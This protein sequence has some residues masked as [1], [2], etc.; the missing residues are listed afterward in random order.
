MDWNLVTS[1]NNADAAY[2]VFLKQ[3]IKLYDDCFPLKTIDI[4]KKSILSPW[5]TKGIMKSSKRK[6]KLY[7]KFLKQKTYKN[8]KRYKN[9]KNIFE[10]VKQR[11]K[12]NYFANL[13]TKHQN[14]AKKLWQTIKEAIGK[15]KIKTNNF[16]RKMKIENEEIYDPAII[17][18]SFN[19][20]FTNIGSNLAAKIPHSEKHFT[21]YLN[22]SEV[23]MTEKELTSEEFE[24][25]FKPLKTN[26]ANGYDDINSN[27]VKDVYKELTEPLFHICKLSIRSGVF[28][29]KMKIAK[30]TPLF[31]SDEA[32]LLKNYRPI[33][34]LPTFSKILERII[35]NRIYS[36]IIEN[37]MLYNK[38]FGFRENCS[39]DLAILKLA[40]EIHESFEK[41][42]YTLGVFVDLSKA[43]DTVD[44]EILLKKLSFFG[45]NGLNLQWFRSYLSNRKQ[46]ISYN[47]NEK[48]RMQP[49]FVEFRRVQYSVHCCF[50]YM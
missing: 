8:E 31:K 47:N 44:H 41:H 17:A 30:V 16:P 23:V 4:K 42:E 22:Q 40:Q 2:E 45:I 48:S 33:S 18:D 32:D 12:K 29:N 28:P 49:I 7:L 1:T 9:Y 34:V 46:F 50:F 36:H 15:T 35:Y 24:S 38:Q 37:N 43:F 26:K 3:F 39:T 10:R 25:A 27:V 13:L 14:N 19:T 6:Q 20:Y 11:S 5:I 21:E